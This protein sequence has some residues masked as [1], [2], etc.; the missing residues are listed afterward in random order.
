MEQ[1]VPGSIV[2]SDLKPEA[3][4]SDIKLVK[5]YPTSNVNGQLPQD[6]IR[7]E[8]RGNG[9]FDPFSAYIYTEIT[10][11]VPTA[12][13]TLLNGV[14]ATILDDS[15]HSLIQRLVIRSEGTELERLENYDVLAKMLN[16]ITMTEELRASNP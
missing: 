8:L 15:A 13:T 2:Y 16:D 11:P 14:G 6:L 4:L 5:Y 3:I 12:S 7:F 1:V 9:Y 10:I